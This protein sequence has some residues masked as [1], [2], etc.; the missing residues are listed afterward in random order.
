MVFQGSNV[1]VDLADEDLLEI[2][3]TLVVF[4]FSVLMQRILHGFMEVR[5]GLMSSLRMS[6]PEAYKSA[7][8]IAA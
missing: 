4:I 8:I 3:D 1:W 5:R 2:K 6:R 7:P